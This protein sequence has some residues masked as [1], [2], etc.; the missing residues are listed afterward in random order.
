M[1]EHELDD[2]A[3]QVA[4]PRWLRDDEQRAWR[5]FLR[6]YAQ[7]QSR[8]RRQL[9][10]DTNLSLAD[11]EVLVSL[12]ESP[13][14]ALR[15]FRIG[16]ALHWEKSRLSHQL[17]RMEKRGLLTIESCADDGRGALVMISQLGREAIEA[18]A[19]LHVAEV[20]RAFLDGLGSHEITELVE[21]FDGLARHLEIGELS[22][23]EDDSRGEL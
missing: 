10:R 5:G 23:C 6:T 2:G 17:T 13:E 21:I 14:P 16:I 20:R 12:S 1:S 8:L 15:P 18:A 22:E 7:V 9:Q 4:D 11:Y 3:T 19:P